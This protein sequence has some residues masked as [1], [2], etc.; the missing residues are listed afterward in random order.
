MTRWMKI[1]ALVAL[2]GVIANSITQDLETSV[3][4][5]L[6]LVATYGVNGVYEDGKGD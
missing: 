6:L 4:L 1:T 2:Y 5:S 3:I